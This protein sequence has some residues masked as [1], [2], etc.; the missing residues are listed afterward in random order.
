MQKISPQKEKTPRKRI[1]EDEA[2]KKALR[3]KTLREEAQ[4]KALR[5]KTL[6]ERVP[7]AKRM[8]TAPLNRMAAIT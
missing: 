7:R 3:E 1:L 8:Q 6:R 2:Q 4:K 5:E